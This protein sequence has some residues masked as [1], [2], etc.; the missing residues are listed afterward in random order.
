MAELEFQP[1][2]IGRESELEVLE[3]HLVRASEGKGATVFISGEAGIGKTRL[4]NELKQIAET[5]GFRVLSGHSLYESMT[6]YMPF[7]EALMSGGLEYLFADKSP[8]VEA[9]YL[10][11]D[12]GLL[13]KEV[14]RKGTHLDADIFSSTLTTVADFVKESLSVF[15]GDEA[16]DSLNRIGYGD[17][18][19]L[20]ES[21]GGKNL[22]VILTGRENEFLIDDMRGVLKEVESKYG[23]VLKDWDGDEGGVESIDDLLKTLMT[24][25]K[26]DG[27][28][29]GEAN[30]EARRNLLMENVTLGLS[31]LSHTVPTLLCIDD[32]QWADP[33]TLALMHYLAR[34]TVT[35]G[36]FVLGAYRPED[37]VTKGGEGHPLNDRIRLMSR[38]GLHEGMELGRLPWE[39]ISSFLPS[40][41][42]DVDFDE[43]FERRIHKET[44]GNPL[45][46]IELARLM[47][48]E[49]II[50][51]DNGT[52]KLG[53]SMDEVNV[54]S[55]IHDVI[56][57]KL[58]R[59]G[60]EKR[61]ILDYASVIGEV[62]RSEI[63]AASL[64][65]ER[66][67]LLELL[68]NLE[69]THKLVHSQNEGYR[70][71][72]SKVKEVLYGKIPA[73][74]K[75]EYHSVIAD[76]IKSLNRDSLD[77]VVE[78]L[79]FHY[80]RGR[81]KEEA[82]RYLI[83]A[84]DKCKK[85]YSN[86]EATRFYNEA[87]ELEEDAQKRLEV[88]EGLGDI[89]RLIG[90]YEKSVE[91]YESALELIEEKRKKA[92]VK[93]RIGAVYTRKGEYGNAI[94]V[95]TEAWN[96][97]E[98][99]DCEEEAFALNYIGVVHYER[100][101]YDRA[102]KS[103]EKS[104]EIREKRGDQKG[105]AG[106]FNNIGNVHWRMGEYDRALKSYERSLELSEKTGDQEFTAIHLGNIG[107]VH[108]DRGEY[109]RA[110]EYYE[111]SLEIREEIGDQ[112]GIALTLNSFGNVHTERGEYDRALE[113]YERSLGISEKIGDQHRIARPLNNVGSVHWSMGEYDR[114]LEYYERSLEIN[115]KI[116]DQDGIATNLNGIGNVHWS[117]GEY[118]RALGYHERS[119]GISE[120]I[121]DREGATESYCR[122]AEVYFEKRNLRRALDFCNRAF[123]LSREVG[124]KESEAASRRIFGKIHREREKWKESIEE[125]EE[126]IRIFEEIGMKKGLGDSH[127]EF[128]LMY[129]DKGDTGKAKEYLDK[130][131]AIFEGMHLDLQLDEVRKALDGLT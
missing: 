131:A 125:F 106:S 108:F 24:S 71:D 84:A 54:P 115:E 126:S 101:E 97:V 113:Y 61:R 56:L 47:V 57:R 26:Y 48:E 111:R 17:Y 120:K 53:T 103:Y 123:D 7:R 68:R 40:L 58:D 114:A 76:S 11:T 91:S 43:E 64:E 129:K 105:I 99:E 121:G 44:E 100:G 72:H 4:M 51:K 45:F 60:T 66:I 67:R 5:K 23:D 16:R 50:A 18:V 31:R 36:V 102:L 1:E 27:T 12:V 118:D 98:G 6:P 59:L 116:G 55:K 109:D 22:V 89:Y 62:F 94:K 52:W 90:D 75:R 15:R 130:A 30:P 38:E 85:E 119:L 29:Y 80:Y 2:L 88:F 19:I 32:L 8:R 73:E 78:D 104:L 46:I 21:E 122:I 28:Y 127:Y 69:Q 79:A 14:V 13:V 35:S 33:S 42:G 70:F 63:L 39:T 96:S 86:E 3:G 110:L 95:C 112:E 83:K 81:N 41:L 10:V 128:G 92:E 37:L 65:L 82:L 117:M 124:L 25:G 93:T 77:E 20:I 74:L 9:V 87:L 49:G 34:N 107:V